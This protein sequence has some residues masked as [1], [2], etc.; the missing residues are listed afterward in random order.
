M[1]KPIQSL[2]G[3]ERV[4]IFGV[5][6]LSPAAS[7]Q[8]LQLLGEIKPKC[9]LIE[10]PSDAN[11]LIGG[12]VQE[13]VVLPVAMLAYTTELPVETVLY[14]LAEYSP[15]Y[16]AVR[17]AK[18]TNTEVGF[19][20]LPSSVML[21]LEQFRKAENIEQEAKKAH[22][23]YD[24][25]AELDGAV[26]FDDYFERNFE[27]NTNEGSFNRMMTLESGEIRQL[28]EP[29]EMVEEPNRS[30]INLVREAYMAKSNFGCGIF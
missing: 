18:A 27:H 2:Q 30:A 19:I 25:I 8:L 7:N 21:S 23:I 29:I 6:H 15:E 1:E 13:A 24:S 28:L 16:Q 26:H 11:S 5:R 9:V 3:I 4:S 10:G 12:L 20:D 14:P 22:T 17:F